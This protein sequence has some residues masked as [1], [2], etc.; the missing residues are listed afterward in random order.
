VL[1]GGCL[2]ASARGERQQVRRH[3]RWHVRLRPSTR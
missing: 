3:S 2:L 1:I